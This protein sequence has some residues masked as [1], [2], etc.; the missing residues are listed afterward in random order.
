MNCEAMN[1]K[2]PL[3]KVSLLLF[4]TCHV[5]LANEDGIKETHLLN[6][7]SKQ[8]VTFISKDTVLQRYT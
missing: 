4:Q 1:C 2:D 3:Y 5:Q 6:L 7:H 8:W